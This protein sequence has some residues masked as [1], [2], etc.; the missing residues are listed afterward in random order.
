MSVALRGDH[1]S[2][3][4]HDLIGLL[5]PSQRTQCLRL[6]QARVRAHGPVGGTHGITERG[7]SPAR[8]AAC[9]QHAGPLE[10][11]LSVEIRQ[12]ALEE[13]VDLGAQPARD[14]AQNPRRG[15]AAAELDLVEE[16]AAEV[17][18]ADL[19]K[20]HA[21]FLTD[22]AD[23]LAEGLL[24]RHARKLTVCKAGVYSPWLWRRA[25]VSARRSLRSW[26]AMWS[27]RR[28]RASRS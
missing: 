3:H 5:R 15:L 14:H 12:P 18:T 28:R 2:L 24:P 27:A 1:L 4:R 6:A 19:G 23:A 25:G 10:R 22:A 21:P 7:Q 20:A 17:A 8:L 26:Y 9:E 13:V 11:K 16:R